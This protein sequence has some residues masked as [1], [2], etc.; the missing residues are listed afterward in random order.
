[1]ERTDV[2]IRAGRPTGAVFKRCVQ[3]L[4]VTPS[5]HQVAMGRGGGLLLGLEVLRGKRNAW[6]HAAKV[7]GSE[8]VVI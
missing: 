6:E 1:M 4:S 2:E 5:E 7:C 8:N 3:C